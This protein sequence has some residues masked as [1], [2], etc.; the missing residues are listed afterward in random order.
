MSKHVQTTSVAEL[1]PV[2]GMTV[3]PSTAKGQVDHAG[4]TY[5]FCSSNCVN[6]FRQDPS[7]YIASYS[8][9]A[10]PSLVTIG[11]SKPPTAGKLSTPGTTA[12]QKD[13]VCGMDVDP[14]TAK[15]HFEYSGKTYYFCCGGCLEKF[16]ADPERYLNP[17]SS[18]NLVQSSKHRRPPSRQRRSGHK[19]RHQPLASASTFAPCA[20]RFARP[21]RPLSKLR[22]GARAREPAPCIQ[23]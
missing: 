5:Y 20:P 4:K 21:T 13:P 17:K 19:R 18:D 16:R 14:A 10:E 11:I 15:F 12:R 9:S 23:N 22:H 1:D 6:K 7:K 3:N 8:A 2:C